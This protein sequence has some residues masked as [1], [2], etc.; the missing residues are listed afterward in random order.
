MQAIAAC[1][2]ESGRFDVMIIGDV[3][4]PVGALDLARRLHVIA[5]D[6]PIL[7]VSDTV[8]NI[9]L[10]LLAEAGVLEVLQKPLESID[11]AEALERCLGGQVVT[12]VTPL[13]RAEI[14]P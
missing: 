8:G 1:R 14:L 2:A 7:I 10:E 4:G 9:R 6:R 12:T 3:V 5:A 13:V 11:L